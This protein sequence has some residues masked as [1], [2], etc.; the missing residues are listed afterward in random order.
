VDY[1][2]PLELVFLVD[3]VSAI[4]RLMCVSALC[5]QWGNADPCLEEKDGKQG[6]AQSKPAMENFSV[7]CLF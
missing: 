3:L 4:L 6:K 7:Y 1:C 5:S 2:L